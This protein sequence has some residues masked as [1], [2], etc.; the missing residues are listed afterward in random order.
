MGFL[1]RHRRQQTPVH[2]ILIGHRF[3]QGLPLRQVVLHLALEGE[4]A[5]PRHVVVASKMLALK[6]SQRPRSLSIGEECID[7]GGGVLCLLG[8]RQIPDCRRDLADL[9]RCDD[10]RKQLLLNAEFD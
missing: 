10:T 3:H 1:I 7:Q 5:D 8:A 6:L 9:H 2:L 4:R